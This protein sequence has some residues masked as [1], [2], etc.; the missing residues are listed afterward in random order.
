LLDGAQRLEK[1]M[2]RFT[3]VV[4]DGGTHADAPRKPAFSTALLEFL[5]ANSARAAK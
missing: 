1:A 2:P 5:A 4:I 3:L